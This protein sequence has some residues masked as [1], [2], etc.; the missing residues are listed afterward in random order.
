MSP[1]RHAHLA[2]PLPHPSILPSQ[3]AHAP[4]GV[5]GLTPSLAL[6]SPSLLSALVI[7]SAL[8]WIF[9]SLI[10][11]FFLPHS[12]MFFSLQLG[13]AGGGEIGMF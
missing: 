11:F 8:L 10:Y 2:A 5:S 4:T 9:C 3:N 7:F 13:L 6:R 1:Q 12:S